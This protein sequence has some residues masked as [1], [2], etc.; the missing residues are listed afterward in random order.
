MTPAQR[1]QAGA[2]GGLSVVLGNLVLADF[3]LLSI[4]AGA[5][6]A[7]I[8]GFV[9]KGTIMCT[10]S[11]LDAWR[12]DD[13]ITRSRLFRIGATAAIAIVA[14]L[15]G[16]S[17]REFAATTAHASPQVER[18]EST[19]ETTTEQFLRGLLSIPPAAPLEYFVNI[20][21][22][23]GQEN[24]LN[25]RRQLMGD[26]P[27]LDIRVFEACANEEGC[28]RY[29]VTIGPQVRYEEALRLL[30]TAEQQGITDVQLRRVTA[31]NVNR[32]Q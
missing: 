8:S 17:V 26:H 24:A 25:R 27:N 20:E 14:V 22:V 12:R 28:N 32:L 11:G 2:L 21:D 16:H 18:F 29:V 30:R 9:F 6:V 4:G 1:F 13:K 10:L 3:S 15:N 31:P 19:E 23:T 5:T 7:A